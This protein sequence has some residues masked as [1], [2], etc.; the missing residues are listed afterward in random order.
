MTFRRLGPSQK[1]S[2]VKS[3]LAG[4]L[5]KFNLDKE[6]ARYEFVLHW[7]DIVGEDIA[8]R[9]RPECIRNGTLVVAV[10]S[11]AWAQELSF[12]KLMILKKLKA[13]L[14]HEEVLRDVTFYVS[15][16]FH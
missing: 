6:L 11:A 2:P 9:T 16:D 1:L 12:N 15:K 13:K 5:A 8:K 3:T 14:S 4:L 7:K 10:C